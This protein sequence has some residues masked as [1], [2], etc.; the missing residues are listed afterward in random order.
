VTDAI[1]ARHD[2]GWGLVLIFTDIEARDA[3]RRHVAGVE[4][5]GDSPEGPWA[6]VRRA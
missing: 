5:F 6:R 1:V 2:D 3:Y 4:D